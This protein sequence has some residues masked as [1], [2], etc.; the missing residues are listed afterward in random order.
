MY[1]VVVAYFVNLQSNDIDIWAES[2][3]TYCHCWYTPV[4]A[5]SRYIYNQCPIADRL[6]TQK[7]SFPG[8]NEAF[9]LRYDYV[10]QASV[11]LILP[12]AG[13]MIDSLCQ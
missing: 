12:P 10:G 13:V 6:I 2:A 8:C 4:H 3:S 11:I 9:F 5:F 7:P 1:P